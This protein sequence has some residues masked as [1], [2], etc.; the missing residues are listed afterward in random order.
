MYLIRKTCCGYIVDWFLWPRPIFYSF[1][2]TISP[3][4]CS[5]PP[6]HPKE[7]SDFDVSVRMYIIRKTVIIYI[8]NGN[9]EENVLLAP[10]EATSLLNYLRPSQYIFI[11]S[12]IA[13]S[14]FIFNHNINLKLLFD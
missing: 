14:K 13:L 4:L 2:F 9:N 3:M 11:S 10:E 8:Y 6:S 7:V 1:Y 5:P 12:T